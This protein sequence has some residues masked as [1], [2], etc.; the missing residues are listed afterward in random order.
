MGGPGRAVPTA[1]V[2]LLRYGPSRYRKAFQS[3]LEE[4]RASGDHEAAARRHMLV[5]DQD[6]LMDDADE[7]LNRKVKAVSAR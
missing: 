7:F 6:E 3:F 1:Y 2:L 4:Y 5:L